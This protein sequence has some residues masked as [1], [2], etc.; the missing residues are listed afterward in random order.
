[1]RGGVED[2]G[3][4]PFLRPSKRIRRGRFGWLE[5]ESRRVPLVGDWRVRGGGV[6]NLGLTSGPAVSVSHR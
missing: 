2:W 4:F 3:F 6:E 5:R 1:M